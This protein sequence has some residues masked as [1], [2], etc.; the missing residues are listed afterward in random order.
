[1]ARMD[2]SDD[3]QTKHVREAYRLLNKSI[4]RVEQPDIQLGADQEEEEMQ[5]VVEEGVMEERPTEAAAAKKKMLLSFEEYKTISNMIVVHMRREE[6]RLEAE[7]KEG[8]HRSD[9][10]EWYLNHV[11]DQIETEEELIEKKDMFEKVLDR[12]IYHDQIIIPLTRVG[13]KGSDQ[14][15]EED[16]MLVVHPNYIID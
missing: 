3:V 11:A 16:P 7:E 2:I 1:M 9:V 8:I 5:D 14:E 4:I 12:L 13:L 6:T 15:T 10:V